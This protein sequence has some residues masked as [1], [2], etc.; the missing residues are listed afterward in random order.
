[1]TDTIKKARTLYNKIITKAQQHG[2]DS[3]P[4][5]EVGD[6]QDSLRA[7]LSLMTSNQIEKLKTIL[8][9]KEII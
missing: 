7:A 6:L 5:H 9:E 3:D 2:E 1:M 4:D 8:K